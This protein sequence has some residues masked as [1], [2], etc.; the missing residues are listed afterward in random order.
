MKTFCG[1]PLYV[2]PEVLQTKGIGSYTAQVD[3]WS[4]GI[5]L[6]IWYVQITTAGLSV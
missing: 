3:I 4:L 2:A 5:I 1:T 6:F